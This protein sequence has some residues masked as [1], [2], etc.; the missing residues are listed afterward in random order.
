LLLGYVIFE[1]GDGLS[2]LHPI[3]QPYEE[4][5]DRPGKLCAHCSFLNTADS[6]AAGNRFG[7][8]DAL[9]VN[10]GNQLGTP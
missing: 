7:K 8:R 3:T 9:R 5:F 1:R 10:H 6:C 4:M 2:S